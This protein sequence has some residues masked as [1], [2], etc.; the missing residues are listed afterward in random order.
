MTKRTPVA[1]AAGVLFFPIFTGVDQMRGICL[2]SPRGRQAVR[3]QS[4]F[5]DLLIIFA[6]STEHQ[7]AYIL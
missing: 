4:R 3:L 5:R 1:L 6:H 2:A 7:T